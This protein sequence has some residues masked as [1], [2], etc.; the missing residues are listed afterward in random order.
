MIQ[1]LLRRVCI[2]HRSTGNRLHYHHTLLSRSFIQC[3]T[4]PQRP[5]H[6][7]VWRD[8]GGVGEGAVVGPE[9]D[10]LGLCINNPIRCIQRVRV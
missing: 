7:E 10:H 9:A 2:E 5:T 4:T 6:I 8:V 3:H 1:Q